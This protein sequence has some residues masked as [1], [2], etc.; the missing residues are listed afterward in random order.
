MSKTLEILC[1]VDLQKQ[2]EAVI[3]NFMGRLK[4]MIGEEIQHRL[5][6]GQSVELP[7]VCAAIDG[8]FEKVM[9]DFGLVMEGKLN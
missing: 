5:A 6:M 3:P 1:D 2:Y 9:Q 4:T 7:D 8:D